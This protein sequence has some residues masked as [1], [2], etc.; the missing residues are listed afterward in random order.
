MIELT[1]EQKEIATLTYPFI[2]KKILTP[3]RG[4]ASKYNSNKSCH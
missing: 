2:I 4:T 1:M 3:W